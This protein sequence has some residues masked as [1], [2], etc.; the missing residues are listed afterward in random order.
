[1][2]LLLKALTLVAA[3]AGGGGAVAQAFISTP[4]VPSG[5]GLGGNSFAVS[6]S[7]AYDQA[8][9]LGNGLDASTSF[10]F[11]IGAPVEAIGVQGAITLTSFRRF[12]ASGYGA[13]SL[14]RMFQTG[15]NGIYSVAASLTYIAPWGN[16][17]GQALGA[18]VIGSYLFGVEG[19]LA[20]VTLGLANDL[21]PARRV[22]P[23]L[24][25]GLQLADRLAISA[26]W[27]GNQSVLGLG[28]QPEFMG[29]ASVNLS[30]RAIESTTR[31]AFGIDVNHA[32]NMRR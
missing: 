25:L 4:G 16:S 7:G 2:H 29:G 17:A 20:M 1:M 32:F 26:G 28:W 21:N 3:L 24:G 13:L 23:V 14:H 8:R 12:G 5:F 6:L 27:V 9:P 19:R 11:G 18:S 31:R 22:E 15:G 10:A 30:V